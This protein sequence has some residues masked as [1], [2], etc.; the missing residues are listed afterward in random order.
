[1]SKLDE[2]KTDPEKAMALEG[3][4]LKEMWKEVRREYDRLRRQCE[5]ADAIVRAWDSPKSDGE[6]T[7]REIWLSGTM[8]T[9]SKKQR[10]RIA[11][12]DQSY[13]N[14]SDSAGM[15]MGAFDRLVD[16]WYG[17]VLDDVEWL[18]YPAWTSEESEVE[19]AKPL[20]AMERLAKMM[21]ER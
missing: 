15:L 2:Y 11:D 4:E 19:K 18:E 5:D 20:T 10:V 12:A 17:E 14:E 8:S 7:R 6:R 3:G 1:M 21:E 16:G 13:L 9:A